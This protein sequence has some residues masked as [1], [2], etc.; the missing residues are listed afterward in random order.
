MEA[1]PEELGE[2]VVEA[3]SVTLAE[4]DSEAVGD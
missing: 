1:V 2:P 3:D 4:R